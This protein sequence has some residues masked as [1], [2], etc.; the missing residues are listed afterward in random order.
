MVVLS[1]GTSKATAEAG[2]IGLAKITRPR[3]TY[4]TTENLA[5]QS[6]N[7]E[8]AGREKQFRPR[9][10]E[11]GWSATK[12]ETK[13]PP[14]TSPPSRGREERGHV[15][16]KAC[17]KRSQRSAKDTKDVGAGSKPARL[18]GH[19]PS[20]WLRVVSLSNH[21]LRG[22]NIFRKVNHSGE[23]IVIMRTPSTS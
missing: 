23:G 19:R 4:L 8:R 17:P 20:T 9:R 10:I 2:N 22:E 1:A 12:K 11:R 6:P 15:G 21:D 16:I 18:R 5:R 14:L 7:Q 13:D 3:H